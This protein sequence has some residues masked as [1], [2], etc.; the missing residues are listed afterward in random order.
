MTEYPGLQSPITPDADALLA[1]LRREGT[2]AR[3]HHMELFHDGEVLKAICERFGLGE[4]L[5]RD[6]PWFAARRTIE[7]HRFLGFD[8]VQSGLMGMEFGFANNTT[9]DTAEDAHANGRSYRDNQAGPITS[10]ADFEAY[11]WPDPTRPEATAA[12]EFFSENLPE[13]MCISCMTGHFCEHLCWMMGYENLCFAL[14]DQPDLVEAIAGRILEYHQKEI[15]QILQFPRVRILW[16]SDDMGYKTGLM[17][18]AADMRKY[19]LSGHRE[20]AHRAHA[21]GRLYLLHSCGNLREII[22]DLTDDV[23]IDGKH[24]FEDT[25]EDVRQVKGDYGQKVA[26]IGGIDV[27]FLCRARPEDIR[28]RVRETLDA[29]LP[30]G[31]YALGTGNSVANYIPLDNYLAMVDEGRQYAVSG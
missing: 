18:S 22:D 14:F 11:P 12:L 23:Q 26:L 13:E 2:P 10:W 25:I 7:V 21:A 8:Y 27:D 5:S 3:V 15:E 1:N 24:S 20:L 9:E 6:D 30:G 4:G 29:C 31:G 28:R 19:V 17:F 16:G